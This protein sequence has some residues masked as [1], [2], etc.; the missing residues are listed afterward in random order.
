MDNEVGPITSR[1]LEA[2]DHF[3]ILHDWFRLL[4]FALD[5]CGIGSDRIDVMLS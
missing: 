3:C 4:H 1:P 2:A 5:H